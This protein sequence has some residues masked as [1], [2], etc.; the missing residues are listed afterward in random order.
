MKRE[1]GGI[2]AQGRCCDRR[3]FPPIDHCE[4]HSR[5]G[6]REFVISR[7]PE[8]LPVDTTQDMPR[9]QATLGRWHRTPLAP[10]ALMI[11]K[12]VPTAS[13]TTMDDSPQ[14]N[15]TEPNPLLRI[16]FLSL[17]VVLAAAS[18]L[19]PHPPNFTPIGAMALFGGAAIMSRFSAFAVP[20][21]A[22]ILSDLVIGFHPAM[23]VVYACFAFYV[24]LGFWLRSRKSPLNIAGTALFGAVVFFVV[25]NLADWWM[26]SQ[27]P[28]NTYTRDF[29]GLMNC[30]VMAIP[31]FGNTLA[32]D[33]VY[34]TI[35]FG[36]LALAES[37]FPSLRAQTSIQPASA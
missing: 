16:G 10:L 28:Y 26:F 7:Q 25:T 29:A 21:A 35:L 22:M 6:W 13:A 34:C 30:F 1:A 15:A 4:D 33:A 2:P 5:E 20:F 12:T 27:A 3:E 23:P 17:L 37:K 24:V 18:R 9:F 8:D 11:E 19:L 32:G 31:F 14:L 36:A